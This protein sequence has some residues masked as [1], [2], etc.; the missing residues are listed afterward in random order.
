MS[1]N[2][3]EWKTNFNPYDLYEIAK[4]R[5][6]AGDNGKKSGG[7]QFNFQKLP[8]EPEKLN[9]AYDLSNKMK[10]SK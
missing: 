3:T 8:F 7:H 1:K 10:S 5:N 6:S 4:L 9:S 2:P